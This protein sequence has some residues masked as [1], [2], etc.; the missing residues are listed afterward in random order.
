[1]KRSFVALF[2]CLASCS[3]AYAAMT[4]EGAVSAASSSPQTINITTTSTQDVIVVFAECQPTTT[5]CS[6]SSVSDVAGLTWHT[7]CGAPCDGTFVTMEEWWAYSPNILTA[8]TVTVTYS[9]SSATRVMQFGVH[10]ANTTTPYDVNVSLPAFGVQTTGGTM[11]NTISTTAA[12]TMLLSVIRSL[13]SLGTIT[14]P[15]GFSQIVSGGANED[16]AYQVVSAAQSSL[17]VTYSWTGT[18]V[19]EVMTTDAIQQASATVPKHAHGFGG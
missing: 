18:S 12:N 8:D 19:H 16:G 2:L 5:S 3:P 17:A 9:G 13:N 10:G 6:V 4:I 1:M 7:R 15:S 14:K 11:T